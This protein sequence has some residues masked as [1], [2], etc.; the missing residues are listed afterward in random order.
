M[1]EQLGRVL[2]NERVAKDMYLMELLLEEPFRDVTPGQFVMAKLGMDLDPLLRRP[3]S[4]YKIANG[5]L[6]I[7]YRV[8]G[9]V[10]Y[11]MTHLAKGRELS[12]MGPLGNGFNTMNIGTLPVLVAGGIGIAGLGALK[13]LLK[14]T[15]YVAGFRTKEEVPKDLL[16]GDHII[17]TCED[18]GVGT[19][20]TVIDGLSEALKGLKGEK[21]HVYACGSKGMLKAVYEFC[22]SCLIPCQMLMESQ[23]ACGV[24]ACQGCV[25]PTTSGYKRVCKEGPV[26]QGDEI[27]WEK[28]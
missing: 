6:W 26:F 2:L 18:G 1:K 14:E 28:F 8:V 7:L 15:I 20:G 4:I 21:A 11:L 3:F 19:K 16:E 13:D 12:L 5:K 23:M 17:V 10:T 9:R 27:L 22:R 24:G 25:I